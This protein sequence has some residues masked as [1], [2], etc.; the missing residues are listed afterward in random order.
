MDPKLLAIIGTAISAAIAALSYWAKTRHD[1][2]RATRVVLF[3]L[4]EVHH[5][6]RRTHFGLKDFPARY[7]AYCREAL[8]G[9]GA[10]MSDLDAATLSV[11][12]QHIL[13]QFTATEVSGLAAALAEPFEKAL[14]ELSREDPVLA[15][16]LRGRDQLMLV[17]R[18]LDAAVAAIPQ[19]DGSNPE[20]SLNQNHP[21]VDDVLREITV[22]ELESAIRATAW[23]CDL[24]THLQV[25]LLLRSAAREQSSG[26]VDDRVKGVADK[27]IAQ[28]SVEQ[29]ATTNG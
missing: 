28:L 27:L 29:G 16:K 13:R 20:Q 3:Y 25:I 9:R 24:V 6:A 26:S 23:R 22:A 18:K 11:A 21:Q 19:A 8:A 7:V 1:R 17:S 10:V 12:L 2:R 4:L 15:F 5:L 14:V